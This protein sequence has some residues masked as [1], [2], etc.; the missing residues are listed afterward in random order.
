MRKDAKT[1]KTATLS[2]V[3]QYHGVLDAIRRTTND[4]RWALMDA[5][6]YIAHVGRFIKEGGLLFSNGTF[7]ESRTVQGRS[8][9]REYYDDDG[10]HW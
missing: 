8:W 2:T 5:T 10:Y 4:C 6:G 1:T 3:D 9:A 7:R